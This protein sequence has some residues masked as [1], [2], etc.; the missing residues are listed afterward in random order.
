MKIQ[1]LGSINPEGEKVYSIW[2][3]KFLFKWKLFNLVKLYVG[4]RISSK[5]FYYPNPTIANMAVQICHENKLLLIIEQSKNNSVIL[6][7]NETETN[8]LVHAFN[9]LNKN[10]NLLNENDRITTGIHILNHEITEGFSCTY[11][12][13]IVYSSKELSQ[14]FN[15]I[16]TELP[17]QDIEYSVIFLL[18]ISTILMVITH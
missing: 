7:A 15:A 16:D 6:C 13:I 11:E 4:G 8:V 10:V 3:K 5:P 2:C 12:Q 14:L 17:L 9:T 18:H 1:I